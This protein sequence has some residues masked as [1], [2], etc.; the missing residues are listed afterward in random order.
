[1]VGVIVSGHFT[2]LRTVLRGMH[3]SRHALLVLIAHRHRDR[4]QVLQRQTG[5][6]HQQGEFFQE[7][8]HAAILSDHSQAWQVWN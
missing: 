3:V 7:I 5:Y 1:M 6:Q 2:R 4:V 8:L